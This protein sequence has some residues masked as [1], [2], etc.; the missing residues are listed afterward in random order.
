[1][2]EDEKT[3]NLPVLSPLATIGELLICQ[4][5]TVGGGKTFGLFVK[6]HDPNKRKTDPVFSVGDRITHYDGEL[7]LSCLLEPAN[8]NSHPCTQWV[9]KIGRTDYSIAGLSVPRMGRGG[10][11]F[12]N[13]SYERHNAKFVIGASKGMG[14]ISY[15]CPPLRTNEVF[16]LL[17]A[18]A[19]KPIY[20]GDEILVCYPRS[21]CIRMDIPYRIDEDPIDSDVA[22]PL[23]VSV[24]LLTAWYILLY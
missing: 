15:S 14:Y 9:A 21:T 12:I 20:E 17:V 18:T 16:P 6:V 7:V 1:M 4:P 11:S 13:H 19:T 23:I 22:P 24:T 8:N 3:P 2:T 10:G 5:S